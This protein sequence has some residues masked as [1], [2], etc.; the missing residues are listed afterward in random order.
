VVEEIGETFD[1]G[2]LPPPSGLWLWGALFHDFWAVPYREQNLLGSFSRP[3]LARPTLGRAR[4]DK[5]PCHPTSGL[6]ARTGPAAERPP[7][8]AL[9]LFPKGGC[10][11]KA[12]R[13][14]I[15]MSAAIGLLLAGTTAE[16]DGPTL[17]PVGKTNI[18]L[19]GADL[20]RR[21]EISATR[22]TPPG[23]F[24]RRLF[25][26]QHA[27]RADTAKAEED[28]GQAGPWLPASLLRWHFWIGILKLPPVQAY[29]AHHEGDPAH[30]QRDARH[31]FD[32]VRL[33]HRRRPR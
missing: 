14:W 32:P 13:G 24:T 15:Q 20:Q 21:P 18:S 28:P 33:D 2:L 31:P 12:A 26:I 17:T 10:A 4:C 1:H 19:P 27:G 30:A 25:P 7:T 11:M 3:A 5:L 23:A 22:I 6:N 9:S 8:R 16:A 29:L